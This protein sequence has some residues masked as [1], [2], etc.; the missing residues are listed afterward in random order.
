MVLFKQD[1]LADSKGDTGTWESLV[2]D[3][4]IFDTNGD[5]VQTMQ[6]VGSIQSGF[7]LI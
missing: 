1:G 7:S 3:S 5:G 2:V 6:A 4:R